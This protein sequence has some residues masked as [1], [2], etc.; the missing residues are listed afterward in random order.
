MS[1]FTQGFMRLR[2]ITFKQWLLFFALMALSFGL[3]RY[4]KHIMLEGFFWDSEII[5]I[6]GY[7][8]VYNAGVAFSMFSFLAEYLKYIQMIFLVFVIFG[9]ILSEFFVRHYMPLG[10]LLGAG[11]SNILDRF[12]YDGVVDYVYW[13]YYFDFAIFNLADVFIDISVGIII[14]QMLLKPE[15]KAKTSSNEIH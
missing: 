1:F 9:A 6:G 2:N 13:H 15:A 3:D 12:I 7:A 8:L 4:V 5:T 14:L 10:V 11:I